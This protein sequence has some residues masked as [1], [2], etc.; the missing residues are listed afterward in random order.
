MSLIQEKRDHYKSGIEAR[1][2][3]GEPGTE[4]RDH[5]KSGT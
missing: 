5:Q 4:E 3:V 1:K 2:T